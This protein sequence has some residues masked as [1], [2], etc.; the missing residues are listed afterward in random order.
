MQ[1]ITSTPTV[2]FGFTCYKQLK[3]GRYLNATGIPKILRY[4]FDYLERRANEANTKKEKKH[5]KRKI[6]RFIQ[7][8]EEKDIHATKELAGRVPLQRL[9]SKKLK[10]LLKKEDKNPDCKASKKHRFQKA[11]ATTKLID[12]LGGKALED[13]GIGNNGA[14][15]ALGF[16][17]QKI[18]I[19]K[20]SP[21]NLSLSKRILRYLKQFFGQRRL[22]RQAKLAEQVSEV[23]RYTLTKTLHTNTAPLAK[24]KKIGGKFGAFIEFLPDTPLSNVQDK[25]EKR[26][27]FTEKE[28]TIWQRACIEDFLA[29][30]LDS[31]SENIFVKLGREGQIQSVKFID[32]GNAFI[33]HNP[34]PW[35]SIGNRH[36]WGNL[37][38]SKE[39]L[40][41]DTLQFIENVTEQD[42]EK[43]IEQ[44]Q[45][46]DP[47]FWSLKM[48]TRMRERFEALK[49]CIAK[50][51]EISL[52]EIAELKR[53]DQFAKHTSK[54]K[55]DL[56]G[57]FVV[58]DKA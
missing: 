5:L 3:K 37:K 39:S 55:F 20:S 19:F 36:A 12:K 2:D 43:F 52:R 42:V 14:Q 54:P 9:L 46:L 35:G 15:F 17:R 45:N 33:E 44:A 6:T 32:A 53:S 4:A 28:K 38:I 30:N 1:N 50:N 29:G 22:C 18:G 40:T 56:Y 27:R 21:Q 47:N 41:A 25:L 10:H 23:A 34:G 31:H 51:S 13:I 49:T 57:S 16:N 26:T 48:E 58:M 8:L 11:I 24:M 7:R